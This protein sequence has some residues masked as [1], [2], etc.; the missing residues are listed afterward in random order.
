MRATLENYPLFLRRLKHIEVPLGQLEGSVVIEVADKEAYGDGKL[1]M[2]LF[3]RPIPIRLVEHVARAIFHALGEASHAKE[4]KAW[5]H[6][7]I[8]KEPGERTARPQGAAGAP[9]HGSLL[10]NV[11]ACLGLGRLSKR[12]KFGQT[13]HVTL[14]FEG[15]Q[16]VVQGNALLLNGI[17]ELPDPD[18]GVIPF[19]MFGDCDYAEQRPPKNG[20]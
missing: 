15:V 2:A 10:E 9:Q 8:S 14:A 5:R 17:H 11:I 13:L 4:L 19:G 3:E 12:R 20:Q 18:K 6:K 7:R 16:R 1:S